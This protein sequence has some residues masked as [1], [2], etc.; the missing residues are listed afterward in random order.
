M[1]LTGLKREGANSSLGVL[2][3][4]LLSSSILTIVSLFARVDFFL[5]S[6]PGVGVE[7]T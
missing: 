5:T 3:S 7:G 4:A 6:G 1:R 2:S